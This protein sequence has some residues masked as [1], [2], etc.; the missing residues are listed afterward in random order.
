MPPLTPRQRQILDFIGDFIER[1]GY[2]PSVEEI[3]R[4]VGLRSKATAHVH[5]ENLRAKGFI[6]TSPGRSRSLELVHS[7]AS[8]D[9]AVIEA[10]LL[11]VVSA[12]SPIEAVEDNETI[13]L[14]AELARGKDNFVL[15]VSGD[16]MIEDHI[17]D[18]DYII[19]RGAQTAENGRT[20]VALIDGRYATVKRFHSDGETVTLS[21]RNPDMQPMQYPADRVTIQGVVTGILRK[22]S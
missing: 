7:R 21:P 10:P 16:S 17:M 18:G 5:L 9:S 12:G 19:V 14:P 8:A 11:G 3:A 20:V 22:I 6:R 15:K 1:R 13:S 2:S 4:G